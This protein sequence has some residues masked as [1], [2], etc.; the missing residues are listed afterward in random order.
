GA[1]DERAAPLPLLIDEVQRHGRVV[2]PV[3]IDVAF[4]IGGEERREQ[5]HRVEHDEQ[6]AACH[7]ERA[8]TQVAPEVA[9]GRPGLDLGNGRGHRWRILGSAS[10]SSTSAT[11]LPAISTSDAISTEPITRYWSC[12]FSASSVR[13]PSPG[14]EK[15][16][17]ATNEPETSEPSVKPNN[18]IMGLRAFRSACPRTTWDSESPFARAVVT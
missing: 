5:C 16:V 1:V 13:L 9:R 12:V 8:A 4:R 17:S 11:R 10:A 15:I 14:Q 2:E 7:R 18:V 3:A 6:S